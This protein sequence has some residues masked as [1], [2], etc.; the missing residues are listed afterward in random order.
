MCSYRS[1]YL[2]ILVIIYLKQQI[3]VVNKAV[4]DLS[5]A[6]NKVV[7]KANDGDSY[8]IAAYQGVVGGFSIL[9]QTSDGSLYNISQL[10]N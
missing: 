2:F 8:N 4:K 9:A 1:D 5:I 6:N 3:Q 7:N 10:M